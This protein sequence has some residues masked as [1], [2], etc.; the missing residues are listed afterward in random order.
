MIEYN[1]VDT[2]T[3]SP[4]RIHETFLPERSL[5]TIVVLQTR[6]PDGTFG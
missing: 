2:D 5:T 6:C 3:K 1:I 4:H